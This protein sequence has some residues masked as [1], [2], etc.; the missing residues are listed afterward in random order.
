MKFIPVM[1]KLHIV[2]QITFQY[3]DLVLK[4][5]FLSSLMLKTVL[6]QCCLVFLWK[7]QYI[8]PGFLYEKKVQLN[9]IYS[10]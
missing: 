2:L 7:L 3:A 8:F 9:S 1:A 5:N 6:E 10:K 4:N